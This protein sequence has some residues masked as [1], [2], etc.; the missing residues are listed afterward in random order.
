MVIPYSQMENIC[1]CLFI[2]AQRGR[3][4]GRKVPRALKYA[5][6]SPLK[7]TLF[8]IGLFLAFV[9]LF[10]CSGLHPSSAHSSYRAR[11]INLD[12]SRATFR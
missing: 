2:L 1:F 5:R 7:T 4:T 11:E 6:V 10:S 9:Q 8:L 3:A 12:L